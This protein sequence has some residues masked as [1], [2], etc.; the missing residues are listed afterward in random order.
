MTL[1]QSL[2]TNIWQGHL[3]TARSMVS[4]RNYHMAAAELRSALTVLDQLN[5]LNPMECGGKS[6][7][8]PLSL[9]PI[10]I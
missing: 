2:L 4:L 3:T 1:E 8:T 7:A 9:P 6:D 10:D 5:A